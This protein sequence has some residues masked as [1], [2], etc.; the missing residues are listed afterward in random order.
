MD[1]IEALSLRERREKLPFRS[2]MRLYLDPFALFKNVS[3]GSHAARAAALDYNRRQRRILL[4]Y[5][6][7]WALIAAA[8]FFGAT[9]AGAATAADPLLCVPFFGLEVTFSL[10][11]C[12]VL[13]SATLYFLLAGRE[14]PT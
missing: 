2:L 13:L 9:S 14:P 4:V 6:R 3:V 8:S 5:L 11:F 12:M 1:E 7:R 10:A